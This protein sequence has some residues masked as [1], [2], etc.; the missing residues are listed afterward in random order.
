ME[1]ILLK[2]LEKIGRKGQVVRVRDGFARN[3]LLP[4]KSAMPL[5][6][7][8]ERFVADQKARAEKRAIVEK[9]KAKETAEKL[10][11]LKLSIQS[12][13]G[14]QD[15]LFGSVT[16]EDI[17]RLLAEKGFQL[18]RRKILLKEPIRSLGTYNLAVEVF[19]QVRANIQ[20]NVLKAS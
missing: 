8:N 18:D 5:T 12:V 4:Q 2:D 6:A 11:G 16:A 20:L 14:D 13:A 19:P 3:F 10:E 1:L 15:K 7:A 9:V 17:S